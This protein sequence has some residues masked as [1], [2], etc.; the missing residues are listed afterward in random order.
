MEASL[1]EKTVR[2]GYAAGW[3]FTPLRGKRPIEK[4]WQRRPRETRLQAI[5]YARRGNV[6]VRTGA[7]SGGLLVVDLDCNKPG[8][9]EHTVAKCNGQ[10][11]VDNKGRCGR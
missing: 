3:S 1:L 2:D 4:G 7:A 11:S 5:D 6:G 9:P 8:F 10:S